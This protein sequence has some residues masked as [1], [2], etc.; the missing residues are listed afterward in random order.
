M[1]TVYLTNEDVFIMKDDGEILTVNECA[2]EYKGG[3]LNF[4]ER[5]GLYAYSEF[6]IEGWSDEYYD[7]GEKA[8]EYKGLRL[9]MLRGGWYSMNELIKVLNSDLMEELREEI[10][11]YEEIDD[12]EFDNK[13]KSALD[14]L[15]KIREEDKMIEKFSDEVVMSRT[16]F[17]LQDR[18]HSKIFH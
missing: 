3:I 8:D 9:K 4:I 14:S 5:D 10:P 18:V 2:L 1:N 16:I 7:D 12:D 17:F 13:L 6:F 15:K 11:L